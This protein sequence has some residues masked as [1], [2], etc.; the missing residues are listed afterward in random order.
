MTLHPPSPLIPILPP[1]QLSA[2]VHLKLSLP[3]HTDR[4]VYIV[5]LAR[6]VHALEGVTQPQSVPREEYRGGGILV[7]EADRVSWGDA[8]EEGVGVAPAIR[9]FKEFAE[10]IEVQACAEAIPARKAPEGIGAA[11]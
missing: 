5:R 9:I 11:S 8:G 3:L 4:S 6:E 7:P 10:V 2:K 1:E